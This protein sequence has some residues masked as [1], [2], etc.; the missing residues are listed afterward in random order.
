V[1]KTVKD[2]YAECA[3]DAENTEKREE[4]KKHRIA[5]GLT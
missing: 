2:F 3:E 1:G 5:K 4:R